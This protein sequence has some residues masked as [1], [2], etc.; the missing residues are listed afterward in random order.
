MTHADRM[1]QTYSTGSFSR[2]V[3]ASGNRGF[4]NLGYAPEPL[5]PG[6]TATRQR[7]L[8]RLVYQAVD[9][10][11]GQTLADLGCGK[12]GMA[13]LIAAA[14][15]GV[16]VLGVN[17]DRH[18]LLTA[19]TA[20]TGFVVADAEQLPFADAAIDTVYAVELL[21]HIRDKQALANECAR[22]LRPG[23]RAVADFIALSRPYSDFN[24]GQRAHLS[25]VAALF[26]EQPHE[27]PTREDAEAIFQRAGLS[28]TTT[29]DLTDGVFAPRHEEFV[30]ILRRLRHRNPFVRRG[31]A[32]VATWLWK[33]DPAEFQEFLEISTAEH[34][35]RF[36][37]Y[38]LMTLINDAKKVG[39]A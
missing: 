21:S 28:V 5:R 16:R 6:S 25:R 29:H 24:L 1:A 18:Q 37:E 35:C 17:I 13:R 36:Y 32:A 23:G 19:Q 39:S 33:V 20:G 9:P 14:A 3:D 4:M 8:A 26:A 12:G 27:V 2:I 22:I 10:A 34:P 11:P 7:S 30:T 38:H 15:P 31:S